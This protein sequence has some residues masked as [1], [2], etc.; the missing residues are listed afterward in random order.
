MANVR[1]VILAAG[2]G[3][4]MGGETPKTII[5][6][7]DHQPLLHYILAG[8]SR[9]GLDDLMVITGHRPQDIE[10]FVSEHWL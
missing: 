4:R 1:G 7:A 8:L 5:P 6:I 2:R 10:S 3:V 9:A